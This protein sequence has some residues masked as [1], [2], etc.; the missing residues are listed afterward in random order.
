MQ[1]SHLVRQVIPNALCVCVKG[2]SELSGFYTFHL[3]SLCLFVQ[4]FSLSSFFSHFIV[5]HPPLR[6]T[7]NNYFL[8]AYQHIWLE[9]MH[10]NTDCGSL[11]STLTVMLRCANR[12]AVWPCISSSATP[13]PPPGMVDANDLTPIQIFLQ[14]FL[15]FFFFFT[16]PPPYW[17]KAASLS[18]YLNLSQIR[19]I[20][21]CGFVESSAKI[22]QSIGSA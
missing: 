2:G 17:S 18:S 20:S 7:N 8:N 21:N 13:R 10:E 6:H 1:M 22:L 14:V 15:V 12:A 9:I 16:P 5:P 4:P 11:L 19:D 3:F